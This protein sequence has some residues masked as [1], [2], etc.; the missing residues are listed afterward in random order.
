MP[1]GTRAI[2]GHMNDVKAHIGDHVSANQIL[3]LSGNT[4]NSTGPHLHFSLKRPDGSLI[5]PTP[6]AEHLANISG[7]DFTQGAI[8]QLL[9]MGGES[10]R[11]HAA[12][13]TQEILF[14]VCDALKDLLLGTTL[15]GSGVLILLKVA[16]WRDGGRWAGVLIF[17]NILLKFLFGGI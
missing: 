1:D 8:P 2:Y 10:L 3:G 9:Q 14:G 7:N 6:H 13:A 5:D 15:V 16:G 12:D 4:G 17:V 11:E